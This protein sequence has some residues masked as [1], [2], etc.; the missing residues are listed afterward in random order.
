M[1]KLQQALAALISGVIAIYIFNNDIP[2]QIAI[3]GHVVLGFVVFVGGCLSAIVSIILI[4]E[5][6][7]RNAE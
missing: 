6:I 7:F 1:T 2:N 4:I 5:L 3:Q